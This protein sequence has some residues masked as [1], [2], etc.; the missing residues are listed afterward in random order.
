M[1]D[2]PGPGLEPV[3]PAL[4]GGFLT[5]APPGKSLFVFTLCPSFKIQLNCCTPVK[6]PHPHYPSLEVTS[7]SSEG[8]GHLNAP[9]RVVG[10][11]LWSTSYFTFS[12]FFLLESKLKDKVSVFFPLVPLHPAGG[13]AVIR[14]WLNSSPDTNWRNEQI[15]SEIWLMVSSRRATLPCSSPEEACVCVCVCVHTHVW[16][17]HYVSG[18]RRWG[19]QQQKLLAHRPL[20]ISQLFKAGKGCDGGNEPMGMSAQNILGW[21]QSAFGFVGNILRKNL[22]ELFGQP[23]ILVFK[24][25][26]KQILIYY[27]YV[28]AYLHTNN[29]KNIYLCILFLFLFFFGRATWLVE[30]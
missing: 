1:W 20:N 8:P 14:Y 5:T 11:C 22:N 21:P 24:Y 26:L 6:H 23:N 3:S 9:F 17:L 18:G 19:V 7:L 30:S 15:K 16:G 25:P 2:L 29:H 13:L 27:Y 10:I 12:Y 28:D 4:A